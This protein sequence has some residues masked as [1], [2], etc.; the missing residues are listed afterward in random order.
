MSPTTEITS[1]SR[2]KTRRDIVL[3]V[4]G[5]DG[6]DGGHGALDRPPV[7]VIL[8][9]QAIPGQ[10]RHRLRVVLVEF[11]PGQ[12]LGAHAL[13]RVL[14]E[15]RLGEGQP[16]QIEHLVLVG[17]KRRDIAK[18]DVAAGIEIHPHGEPLLALLKADGIELAGAL[19][20]HGGDEI[21]EPFLALRVLRRAATEGEP[22]GD[23]GIGVA[24]DEPGFDAAGADDP[25]Y[26]HAGNLS[27][28]CGRND[29]R[30]RRE[31]RTIAQQ[32]GRKPVAMRHD[33][34][35][36]PLIGVGTGFSPM[37]LVNS[38]AGSR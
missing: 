17:R 23:E 33:G 36:L 31:P 2:A 1:L 12:D 7:R 21:G 24:L 38:G 16:H 22:H 8:K 10:R 28:R 11:Q 14:I 32:E 5:R 13:D 35:D 9:G 29:E 18:H 27:R 4:G 26:L 15:P 25:L 34:Y 6:G 19:I 30:R 37:L 3:K 20:H